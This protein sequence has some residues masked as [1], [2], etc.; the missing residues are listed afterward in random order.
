[1][2]E[3][4]QKKPTKGQKILVLL[5]ALFALAAVAFV[6]LKSMGIVSGMGYLV[7]V[8]MAGM[9]LCAGLAIWPNQKPVAIVLLACAAISIFNAVMRLF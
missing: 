5:A 8:C 9:S 1:M 6:F 2:E 3:N 7:Y 4:K